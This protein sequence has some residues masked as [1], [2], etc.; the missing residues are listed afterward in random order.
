MWY[1]SKLQWFVIWSVT[2]L[3]VVG[4][5]TTDP[6]PEA[7]IMPAVL[8]LALFVWQASADFRHTKG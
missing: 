6:E 1:P 5:L 7:F 8:V 2:L 4:W 3:C